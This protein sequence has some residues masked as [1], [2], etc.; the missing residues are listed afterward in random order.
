MFQVAG[1]DAGLRA[2]SGTAKQTSFY[3]LQVKRRHMNLLTPRSTPVAGG[4]IPPS[5]VAVAAIPLPQNTL[6][7]V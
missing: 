5:L 1:I 3:I 2:D 4:S 7:L 6:T